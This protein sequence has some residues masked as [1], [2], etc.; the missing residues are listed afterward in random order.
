[1]LNKT[2]DKSVLYIGIEFLLNYFA[3]GIKTVCLFQAVYGKVK[4]LRKSRVLNRIGK[5]ENF[6]EA[7]SE[8]G[9]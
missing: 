2:R 9:T 4:H 5:T 8:D 1:M 3:C 6:N 7:V